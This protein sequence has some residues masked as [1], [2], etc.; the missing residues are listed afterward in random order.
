MAEK[1]LDINYENLASI[2]KTVLQKYDYIIFDSA[3]SNKLI[4][5][6]LNA[7][8]KR[9]SFK[10]DNVDSIFSEQ[11]TLIAKSY[12]G[13]FLT[14]NSIEILPSLLEKYLSPA[15]TYNAAIKEL[16][17]FSNL[18]E[19]LAPYVAFDFFI[20]CVN[21]PLMQQLLEFVVE[22]HE[23]IV[24]KQNFSM[25]FEEKILVNLLEVYYMNYCMEDTIYQ[26]VEQLAKKEV[27]DPIYTGNSVSDY[28][29]QLKPPLSK[30][31]EDALLVLTCS[32]D[33][34]AR[35]KLIEHN[36]RLVVWV[37]KRYV[38]SIKEL[39]FLD[40]IQEGNIGLINAVDKF[41][42]EKGSKFSTYAVWWIR[43]RITRAIADKDRV[44]RVPVCQHARGK[45]YL[46]AVQVFQAEHGR[47][48]TTKELAEVL[49]IPY[50]K[51]IEF[52]ETFKEIVSL[53]SPIGEDNDT[54]LGDFIPASDEI[55][56]EEQVE[57]DELKQ[58]V[59][60]FLKMC[61][62]TEREIFVISMSMGIGVDREYN[63][64]EV[65]EELF[66]TRERVRQIREI[67]L[68]KLRA[69]SHIK[70]FAVY[71]D[72]PEKAIEYL[73]QEISAYYQRRNKNQGCQEESVL[74][75]DLKTS[76][77]SKIITVDQ[78]RRSR[79]QV[80]RTIYELFPSYDKQ[81]VDSV[82]TNLSPEEKGLIKLRY[83]K[84]LN[85]PI[86]ASGFT[87]YKSKN[88][89]EILL[90]K[91]KIKLM[92]ARGEQ[93][94]FFQD[95]SRLFSSLSKKTIYDLFS[96]FSRE[97]VNATIQMLTKEEQEFLQFHFGETFENPKISE[98][99]FFKQAKTFYNYIFPKMRQQLKLS[100][101]KKDSL[102]SRMM[103]IYQFFEEYTKE[104]V[105]A[106]IATL[107]GK[108]REILYL[109]YGEDLENPV[110]NSNW[111]IQDRSYFYGTFLRKMG[112][113]LKNGVSYEKVKKAKSIY[114][115]FEEYTKE[116]VDAVIATLEG[117]DREIL[118]SRYGEDLEHPVINSN[119]SIQDRSYFYGTLLRKM[120]IA[121]KNGGSYSENKNVK[122][123]YELLGK[124]TK[125]EIDVVIA[126]LEEKDKKI[127][128]LRYGEDL[129]HP[130]INTNWSIQDKHYFYNA[131]LKKMKT[132]LKNGGSCKK[133]KSIYELF[134]EYTKEEVDVAIATLKEK[135]RE[136]LHLRY[137]EDL[138][139]PV[140]N[141]NWT[142]NDKTRFYNSLLRKIRIAL[143]NGTPCAEAKKVKSIYELLGEYTK[144]EIDVVIAS[145]KEK[146]RKM[147]YL[148][149]GEDLEHP[150]INSNWTEKDKKYFYTTLLR[151]IRI[152]LKNSG[153]YSENKKVKSIYEFFEEYT[154]EEVD[155]VIASLE[156]KDKKILYLRYG[157]DLEHPVFNSN[158]SIQDKR[159][160]Y[161]ALL[162]KMKIAL[163]NGGSCKKVKSIYE[164]FEEYTKEEVNVVIASLRGKDRDL[165]YLRYGEDLEHP[166]INS[167]WT[168]KDQMYFYNLLLKKMRTALKNG[169]PCAEVKKVKSIYELFE[170]YTKEEVDAVIASLRG[171][172]RDLL[173]LRY[174][175]D[176]ENPVI[177]SN[178]TKK[179]RIRFYNTLL[180]KMQT[181]LKNSTPCAEVKKVKSIYEFFE[182]YTKEEVD[183]AIATLKEKDKELLHL[184]YG[185]DLEH[186]VINS[187]WSIQDKRYFYNSLLRKM[188]TALKN[189]TS[190]A[191]PRKARS[192]YELFEEYTKEEVDAAIAT[193]KEKDKE[194]LHL[195]YGEDLE[196]PVFNM[197]WNQEEKTYFYTV[198]LRKINRKLKR[199]TDST[200]LIGESLEQRSDVSSES[201]Q[202][203][204]IQDNG[205]IEASQENM[206]C[207]PML[208]M[209]KDAN[210]DVV[211]KVLSIKEAVILCLSLGYVN[212]QYL[213]SSNIAT[214]LKMD[215]RE[216]L[217][218]KKRALMIY[219]EKMV[220]LLDQAIENV[221]QENP[222]DL[223]LKK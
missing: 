100:A 142:E 53:E 16:K 220:H 140:I 108:D 215:E 173:Y 126:S 32:G 105:D 70:D 161:N 185:E 106:V 85:H 44:I 41:N 213:S 59:L 66:I 48:P 81:E 15:K 65:A 121:L 198:L 64:R 104:E 114:H 54:E 165:L 115:F 31:E 51:V 159:Y 200:K 63:L 125:K 99:F 133:V 175:E 60:D 183:M 8:L 201:T 162:K 24:K 88:F 95:S 146:D 83:G 134:G 130:V 166:V 149:Y 74:Q 102:E 148:R 84:D 187:N 69:S 208:K 160:F 3:T 13:E 12:V 49:D 136:L 35:K 177:N 103:T 135:D 189:N 80:V 28:I 190:D 193:L 40:L 222:K 168:E 123:I 128:Y 30:E 157:E 145:L 195:R 207:D 119:W 109:R 194:L 217:D 7:C 76:S 21:V 171:K 197:N 77:S 154:K 73:S 132:A 139:H 202:G 137:G 50:Q 204:A 62:L 174:G 89:L 90:P 37:A 181:A 17:K 127:L 143:K 111:S 26:E 1:S 158:W 86:M 98:T 167:N 68:K 188:Q 25:I 20:H 186:P 219:K 156:G 82:L 203:Q 87:A 45:Q 6:A 79:N 5:K 101:E 206:T 199:K 112:I 11:F 182:E 72:R 107:E 118:Y 9:K 38:S 2:A 92:E 78:E 56:V 4:R 34:A 150:V 75:Q 141:S 113:A 152:A 58:K 97:R 22:E 39:S 46:N 192:I 169:T 214:F 47:K 138:E 124:Y 131:L 57:R 180:R 163:K 61:G 151:K 223:K 43:Q 172:D 55:S 178:W 129:E 19:E 179:D 110:F 144:K 147:L 164:F 116:E 210:F 155:V 94:L 221:S 196:N 122:S 33:A 176:L 10:K 212:N 117:K 36:L 191:N 153:S 216:V 67:A 18:F 96:N 29:H 211:L 23:K 184:R 209:L 71:M 170:G 93:G 27:T 205:M 42:V 91:I 218:I 52:Q 14:A 120:R